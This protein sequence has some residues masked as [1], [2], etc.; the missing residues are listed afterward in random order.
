MNFRLES[1]SR[2]Y[3]AALDS[4]VELLKFQAGGGRYSYEDVGCILD[5]FRYEHNSV[6]V[7]AF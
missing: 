6:K 1:Q 2:P 5:L 4:W 7:L 3:R